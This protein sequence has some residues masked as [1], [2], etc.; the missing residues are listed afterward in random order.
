MPFVMPAQD[1]L[2]SMSLLF[3]S[4]YKEGWWSLLGLEI[5]HIPLFLPRQAHGAHSTQCV[6]SSACSCSSNS[7]WQSYRLA[8]PAPS[9]GLTSALTSEVGCSWLFFGCPAPTPLLHEPWR[10]AC[11]PSWMQER[12]PSCSLS[13]TGREP[14]LSR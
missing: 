10:E 8:Y 12:P 9:A 7:I 5:P 2:L 14:G 4:G 13:W 11:L 3:D 1:T 6:G